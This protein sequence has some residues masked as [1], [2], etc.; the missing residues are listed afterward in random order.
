MGI[1]LLAKKRGNNGNCMMFADGSK[2]KKITTTDNK[3]IQAFI[4]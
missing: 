1:S 2:L 4:T 3:R